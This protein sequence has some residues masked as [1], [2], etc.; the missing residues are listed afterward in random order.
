MMTFPPLAIDMFLPALT[1][2]GQEFKAPQS[3]V[4]WT[5]SAFLFGFGIG[6]IFWGAISDQIGRKIPI[7]VGI[8]LYGLGCIGCSLST[9]IFW[10]VIWR[11]IQSLGACA[12]PV[13][14]R[15]MV[16]DSF[17]QNQ[18]ASVLSLMQM[19]I[20]AAPLAAPF[21]GGYVL[22]LA[23]WRMIFWVQAAFGILALASL[24]FMPET[25]PKTVRQQSNLAKMLSN[26]R[27]LLTSRQFL[28]YVICSSFIYAGLFAYVAG[29]PFIYIDMFKIRP[30]H[31]GYLFGMNIFGLMAANLINARL[32]LHYGSDVLL[33]IGCL[34]AAAIGPVLLFLAVT[35][36][37]GLPALAG[38]LFLVL[39]IIGFVSANAMAGAMASFPN[40]AGSASALTGMS[41]F[42]CGAAGA[43]AVGFFANGTAVSMAAVICVAGLCGGFSNLALCQIK[44]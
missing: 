8:L 37:G 5:L 3:Y 41:Q 28:G 22:L 42:A 23:S 15:A 12:G 30:E 14:A 9:S 4:E 25:L 33:R 43:A 20:C 7:T 39:S 13:L 1:R 44:R 6:Q 10:L 2:I 17:A 11:F 35:G 36:V 32:V 18:A 31:Y 16:R 19:L 29:T 24:V 38:T 40:F 34:S 21:I 26:Y 27:I